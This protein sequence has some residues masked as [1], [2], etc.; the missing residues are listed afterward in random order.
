[1]TI[2]EF[3]NVIRLDTDPI[4]FT[5]LKQ[6]APGGYYS[7]KEAYYSEPEDKVVDNG[8]ACYLNVCKQHGNKNFFWSWNWVAFFCA[9]YICFL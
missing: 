1:M 5:T 2:E 7:E 6:E 8:T 4:D 9:D 3:Y